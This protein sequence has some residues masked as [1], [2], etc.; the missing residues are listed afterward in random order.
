[1]NVLRI[2][3]LAMTAGVLAFVLY[4][5]IERFEKMTLAYVRENEAQAGQ[6]RRRPRLKI[7]N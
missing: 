3:L 4:Q 1:M 6:R 5:A 7:K 2:L